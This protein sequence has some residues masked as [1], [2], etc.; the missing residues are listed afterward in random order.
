MRCFL[1]NGDDF[2]DFVLGEE[3]EDNLSLLFSFFFHLH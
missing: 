3:N 1:D 2:F